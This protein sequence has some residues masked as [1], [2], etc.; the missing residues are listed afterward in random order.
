MAGGG[1]ALSLIHILHHLFYMIHIVQIR[2][3]LFYM[4]F[5]LY[6]YLLK[7]CIRDS[8]SGVQS[9]GCVFKTPG[10]SFVN[11]S[12]SCFPK[13]HVNDTTIVPA[14]GESFWPSESG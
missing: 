11:H 14:Q 5:M 2:H 13:H 8:H 7:M 12:L 9:V 4:A 1:N 6:M 3:L 10:E